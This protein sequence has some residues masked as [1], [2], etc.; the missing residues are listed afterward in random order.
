MA[1]GASAPDPAAPQLADLAASVAELRD[2]ILGVNHG[3]E[4][5]SNKVE[6]YHLRTDNLINMLRG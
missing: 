3:L 4:T 1:S 6:V 2:M 5:L